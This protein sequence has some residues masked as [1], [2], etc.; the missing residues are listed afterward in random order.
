MKKI[1]FKAAAVGLA[2]TMLL[3]S[4]GGN[5]AEGTTAEITEET[6]ATTAEEPQYSYPYEHELR[7]IDDNYRNYYEVF[8]YSFYDSDGD[9]IGD[10]NGL[11]SKLD[12]IENMGFNGIWLMP[13]MPSTTYHK[14]DVVDYFDIDPQYGSMEDFE[15]LVAECDSRGIKLIIDMVLNHTSEKHEWFTTAVKALKTPSCGAAEGEP[16]L[17]E[18]PCID[19]CKY[20]NY[21]NFTPEKPTGGTYYRAGNSDYYYEA[22]FWSGMPDLNLADENLRRNI[23]EIAKFWLDKGVGGFR[24]DAAKEYYTGSVEKNVEVLKWFNDYCTSVDPDCYIVCEVWDSFMSYTK[25]YESGVDSTFAFTLADSDGKISKVLNYDGA[26]NSA[27]S[28]AEAM[29]TIEKRISS[30]NPD[31]IDAPFLSNHDLPRAAGFL[32]N[33]PDKIKMAAG[34]ILT[35]HGSPFVYYGEEIGMAGSGKDENKRAPMYWSDENTEGITFTPPGM[36]RQE[37]KFEPWDKQSADENSILNY[38]R[39]A[40]RLRNE[41]PCIA[42]GTSQ[43]IYLSD[44]DTAAVKRTWGDEELIILY[45]ISDEE[46]NVADDILALDTL[47][48]RGYITAEYGREVTLDTSVS[49]PPYSIVLLEKK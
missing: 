32:R 1:S 7:I 31:G 36:E 42:R 10:I 30:F 6:A 23:E 43:V 20:V 47:Q 45:N 33:D 27:K 25:Y 21:Y 29:V 16:C 19:H 26:D 12:Y 17:S 41:N 39:R 8:L 46:K 3:C 38:Y 37:N 34:M 22:I 11:I 13:I 44:M 40:L 15:R 2:M 48:I 35:M 14:Y 28:F 4:C 49:M 18:T 5:A 9:G 24:L